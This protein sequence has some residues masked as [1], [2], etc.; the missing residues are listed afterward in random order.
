M[1]YRSSSVFFF[2]LIIVIVNWLSS[3]QP[4]VAKTDQALYNVQ[5]GSCHIPPKIADLPRTIWEENILPE[6]AVRMGIKQ[7]GY[8]PLKGLSFDE[9]EAVLKTGIY[10]PGPG[11]NAEDWNRLRDYI[12]SLAPDSI[13]V[14][15]EVESDRLSGFKEKPVYIDAIPGS[16]NITFLEYEKEG[17][18]LLM[19]DLQGALVRY[20]VEQETETLLGSFQ[21][22]IISYFEGSQQ[23]YATSIG[24]L[25]PTEIP[26]G[27]LFKKGKSGFEPKS[28]LLHRPVHMLVADLDKDGNEE[29]VVSEF[30]NHAGRLSIFK[31]N[32][33]GE[34]MERRVLLEQPGCIRV[35]D[36]DMNGDGKTD[37]V[38][39]TAQG[40]EGIL[41]LYQEEPLVFRA[42]KVLRFSPVYGS[43]WFDLL[44]Y[45]G[46]GDL[47]IITVNGDNADKSYV[48]KP[49]HGFRIHLNNGL[50]KFEEAYFYP[51][52]GAT[53]VVGDDFDQDGDMD[54][55][56]AATFPD[57][58]RDPLLSFVYLNNEESE[59]FVF[60]TQV[61][62]NPALGRWLLL[63]KGDVDQDGDKDLILSPFT[64]VFTP[65]P[66]SL[67][68]AWHTK[69]VD[70]LILENT[71]L[72]DD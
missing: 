40:D 60:S 53:R 58:E 41:I 63:E 5:C 33:D 22:P 52:N 38:V 57:Y 27:Q 17:G 7:P 8:N 6:M 46:D 14:I 10:H 36:R 9:Q 71:L 37:L 61:L 1:H 66:D 65:V 2:I 4:E 28:D 16:R 39:L 25:N 13:A 45:E 50:N 47:D 44:D 15:P 64:Y 29:V 68:Q 42:E 43:S 11:I 19:A 69:G 67:N 32:D 55:A 23:T 49:Y 72:N 30:G 62:E 12:L 3:C 59:N 34:S 54:F 35:M 56:L 26:S 20:D 21:N 18:T 70:L 48:H 24:Q 31:V 51:M